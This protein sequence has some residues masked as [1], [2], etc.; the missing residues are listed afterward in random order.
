MD[1]RGTMRIASVGDSSWVDAVSDLTPEELAQALL[2]QGETLAGE[3]RALTVYEREAEKRIDALEQAMGRA[4]ERHLAMRETIID[5]KAQLARPSL[6]DRIVDGTLAGLGGVLKNEKVQLV[7]AL[8]LLVTAVGF[9]RVGLSGHGIEVGPRGDD[10]TAGPMAQ[11][12][13][14][15][16]GDTGDGGTDGG[17]GEDDGIGGGPGYTYGD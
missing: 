12:D 8:V 3:M 4:E 10:D 2:A 11:D 17:E 7:L 14:D 5:L 15:G 16:G 9:F 1:T 6:I 13:D